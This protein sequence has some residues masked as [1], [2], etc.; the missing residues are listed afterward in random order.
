MTAP[1]DQHE[2]Y[3][4]P[5]PLEMHALAMQAP[6][7]PRFVVQDWMPEGYAVL[8]AGH[9]GGGKSGISLYLAACIALGR[10]FFGVPCERR[11]VLYMSCEDRWEV[12]HWRLSHIARHLGIDLGELDGWLF[13]HDLVGEDVILWELDRSTGMTLTPGFSQLQRRMD[14]TTSQVLIVDGVADTFG[15]NENDRGNVKRY[16]N[17]LLSIIPTD[18]ALLLIAHVDKLTARNPATG[19]GFSGSTGWHNSVRARWYL[20]PDRDESEEETREPSRDLLL[21]LQKSNLGPSTAAIRFTWDDDAHLFVGRS[22]AAVGGFVDGIRDNTERDAILRAIVAST[23]AGVHVPAAMQ[24]PRTAYAV[25]THRDEFPESLKGDQRLKK[26]RF[27]RH[28]E[29][30]RHIR[31]IAD[32]T[33]RRGNRHLTPVIEPTTEGRAACAT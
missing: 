27:A 12:L 1:Y 23:D 18:G 7:R 25:L 10:P 4:W 3:T 5:A 28:L 13:L 6:G 2:R 32:S 17:S 29:A 30:L 15:G 19:Q 8:L 24:G 16:V 20:R 33:I 31:H 22:E 9:G 21:E 11:R 14:E 26:R